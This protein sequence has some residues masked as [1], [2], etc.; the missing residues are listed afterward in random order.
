MS[1]TEVMTAIE[2]LPV[3]E[4]EQV[5]I[6]LGHTLMARRASSAISLIGK[7]LSFDK[8]CEVVFRVNRELLG[9]LA[10]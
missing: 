1:V 5:F 6:W 4:Q 9:M 2:K 7:N 8:A 3:K 10:K